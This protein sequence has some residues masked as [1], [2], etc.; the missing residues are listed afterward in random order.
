M[1]IARIEQ[2]SRTYYLS[3]YPG[4]RIEDEA[5]IEVTARIEEISPALKRHRGE[6]IDMCFACS[7]SF[8]DDS[9][10]PAIE[11]PVLLM[12]T[13]KANHRALMAYLPSDAFWAV[14]GMIT[15]GEITYI[16]VSFGPIRY[17]N[18]PLLSLHWRR[19]KEAP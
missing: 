5:R 15:S 2:S 16:E 11:K 6:Q 9:P 17:G 14:A 8:R 3:E 1:L 4:I 10:T 7:R 13:L 12:V 19:S 18:G